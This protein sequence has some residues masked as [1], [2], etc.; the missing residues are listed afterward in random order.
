VSSR[1]ERWV[2]SLLKLYFKCNY[3]SVRGM[4][5]VSNLEFG[6]GGDYSSSPALRC[7]SDGILV[8]G[9]L[10]RRLNFRMQWGW[11]SWV[12]GMRRMSR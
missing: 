3:V 6:V 8:T 5:H 9:H 10:R 7:P 1:E 11:R 4:D 2:V 12:E